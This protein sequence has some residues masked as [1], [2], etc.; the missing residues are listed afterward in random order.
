MKFRTPSG[1]RSS[2]YAC[3]AA[4]FFA[5]AAPARAQMATLEGTVLV[6]GG[7][8]GGIVVA[9][10]PDGAPSAA[11][12][13]VV[14]SIDQRGL[15]FIPQ[16]VAVPRGSVVT[17]PNSDPVL[18]NIFL[19]D[20]QRVRT[21]L[22]TFPSGEARQVTLDD[23]GTYLV[24]CH[25]HPEMVAS[26]VVLD[27]PFST[28]SDSAGR[29]RLDSVP[30]GAYRVVLRHRRFFAPDQPLTLAAGETRRVSLVLGTIPRRPAPPRTG[31]LP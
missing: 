11:F 26:V 1:P 14:A 30:P 2:W 21:D 12:A 19:V 9:L 24:M 31:S 5:L 25:L 4:L 20:E 28:V 22:G 17:F 16:V 7:R 29:F 23:L 8:A 13:P 15:R 3:V 18:H 6:P 10:V 27:T